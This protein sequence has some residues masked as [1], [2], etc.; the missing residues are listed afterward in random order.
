LILHLDVYERQPP[1]MVA[2]ILF[3][4]NAASCSSRPKLR[5]QTRMLFD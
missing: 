4:R 3:S 1:Q 2:S 5:S